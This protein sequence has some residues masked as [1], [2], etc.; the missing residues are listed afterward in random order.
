MSEFRRP[1]LW[2]DKEG[3]VTQII[4]ISPTRRTR[5]LTTL[6]RMMIFLWVALGI[7]TLVVAI[8]HLG[9]R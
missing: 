3:R 2:V 4:D 8:G 1:G 6:Y 5:Q 7:V 9:S